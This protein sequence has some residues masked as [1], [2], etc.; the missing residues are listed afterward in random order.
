MSDFDSALNKLNILYEKYNDISEKLSMPDIVNNKNLFKE[1]SKEMSHLEPIIENFKKYN[2]NIKEI[3]DLEELIK[4]EKDKEIIKIAEEELK[5]ALTKKNE[6]EKILRKQLVPTV[7]NASKNIIMEIRAGTGGEEAALFAGDLFR[8]YTRYAEKKGW[9][10]ATIS[11][12]ETGLGGYKEIIFSISGKDVYDNLRF[13]YGGH[14][15]QR[16]PVTESG[17]RI[18]TSAVT[19]AVMPEMEESDIQI[20]NEDLR[21]DV[22][23]AGGSGGQHV[24]KTESAVRI[25]HIPTGI[26]VQCQDSPSQHMNK[27]SAMKVLRSRL[28]D[29]YEEQKEKE[30]SNLRKEQVGSGD[31]SQKIRTYNFP[32]NRVTDHRINL[33]LYKLDIFMSG[34]I[35]E[36]IEALKEHDV[37]I[38]MKKSS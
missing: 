11:S 17:G 2:N 37:E 30:I 4:N 22:F 24:N 15:V 18:H 35:D 23:R 20:R 21:I 36:M 25:T 27:N 5:D 16:I 31:R 13:E 33:T 34:E 1:L 14:R 32:Q 9:K 38:R 19:V 8:M 26:V 12:N 6:L 3:N 10:V 29:Y 7:E 28:Y